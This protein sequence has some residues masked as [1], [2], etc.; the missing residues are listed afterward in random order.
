MVTKLLEMT[1]EQT[2]LG[3]ITQVYEAFLPRSGLLSEIPVI[4]KIIE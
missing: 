1:Q 4:P 3:V 2:M